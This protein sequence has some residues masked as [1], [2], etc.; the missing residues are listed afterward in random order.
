MLTLEVVEPLAGRCAHEL[1]P[2]RERVPLGAFRIA[3]GQADD[4][5][6]LRGNRQQPIS[7]ARDQDWDVGGVLTDVL[8]D[9]AQVVD[10]LPRARIRDLGGLELRLDVAGAKAEARADRR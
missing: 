8:H 9:V 3:S 10:P 4:A 6:P 7:V 5:S 2:L 1:D